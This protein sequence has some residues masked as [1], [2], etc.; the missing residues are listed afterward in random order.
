MTQPRAATRLRL[1]KAIPIAALI[2][3]T[4]CNMP[5]PRAQGVTEE[6]LQ[7]ILMSA[8]AGEAFWSLFQTY[9]DYADF[10][11]KN[12]WA[13]K[14]LYV[15]DAPFVPSAKLKSAPGYGNLEP[16]P[17][18]L[19][20]NVCLGSSGAAVDP[21][22]KYVY[23]SGGTGSPGKLCGFKID[24]VTE[25]FTPIAGTPANVGSEP[26]GIAIVPSGKFMYVVSA[27]QNTVSGFTINRTTGQP[28][29]VAGSPFPTNGGL[30]TAA[31]TDRAG[32]FLYVANA[33]GLTSAGG[34]VSVF[35]IDPVTGA[36]TPIAGS[37]FPVFVGTDSD[38]V[39]SLA[40]TPDGRFLLT[41]GSSL[42]TFAVNASTGGL[43]R[44][45]KRYIYTGNV[46]IDPTGRFLFAT[47]TTNNTLLGFSIAA[48]GTLA[49][50]GSPQS[51]GA[52][53]FGL[54]VIGDLVYATSRGSNKLFGF[55][56]N[57]GSG[58]LTAVLGSPFTTGSK[59]SA[60]AG[61]GFLA[62]SVQFD[63]GD[64]VVA[65]LGVVGGRAPYTW[66]VVAGAVPPGLVLNATT[67]VIAGTVS[68][69][70]TYSFTLRVTDSRG[71]TS[72]AT[73]SIT[74]VGSA[75]PTS[76]S[77][78]E[79]YNVSL[80]HYF[81]TY[82]TDEIAKLDN[83]TFKGWARTGLSFNAFATTQSGTSAVC[84]IYI[85]PGKGDGH[86]FGRDTNEC[87]G[88]MAKNP[89]FI[90]ESSAFLHLYPP[91]LGTC[92][93]GQ[94]PVYRVFSNRADANHRYATSRAVRDQMVAKG[95]L[96]EGDGA[97]IVVMCAPA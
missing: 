52:Q 17:W 49:P 37:P 14:L 94:V 9:D 57:P 43:T 33:N 7:Q 55:R 82:V 36:L 46:A 42:T 16:I 81:I 68:A 85:P 51:L 58:A 19:L 59:P 21:S 72:S 48:D 50:A 75:M 35:S 73:K 92:A 22:G 1:S 77:V 61:R 26:R 65:P 4:L 6:D 32:R 20:N 91:T 79:F 97:D 31:V 84:R 8:V 95:W 69:P 56:I 27:I 64:N 93:T 28:T 24:P 63:A 34:T 90:L 39:S 53:A 74:V 45:A 67:G 71:A 40:L 29:P 87:D 89:T 23:F 66:S 38:N 13:F 54:T 3:A 12:P 62:D 83:G 5:A 88:T 47:E 41:G 18:A 96:A 30:S 25:A 70:G 2:V 44:G 10:L 60:L 80:D 11:N 86:F 15:H 78:V 76:V